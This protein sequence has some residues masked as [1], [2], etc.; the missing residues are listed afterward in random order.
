[1]TFRRRPKE[2]KETEGDQKR[3]GLWALLS[4]V[5]SSIAVAKD[6]DLLIGAV[7]EGVSGLTTVEAS[8]LLVQS[9][10]E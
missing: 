6:E 10:E 7:L 5:A 8:S 9:L 2:T 1:M 4:G 3:L